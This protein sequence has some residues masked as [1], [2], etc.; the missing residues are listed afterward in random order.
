[1][2][3]VCLVQIQLHLPDTHSLK[4][5]RKELQGLKSALQRRFGAA[6]AETDHHDLWQR[7]TLSA[8]VVSRSARGATESAAKI[9]RYVR[10]RFPDGV[11]TER[12][13]VSTDELLE[14]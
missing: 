13:L 3:F 10:S 8:A 14:A 7:A 12:A 6:V 9:E 11:S 5:K 2:S 1:L 4:G